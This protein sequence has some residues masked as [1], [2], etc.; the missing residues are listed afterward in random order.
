[1]S[2]A[3][4]KANPKVRSSGVRGLSVE[5]PDRARSG[6]E[7]L[8]GADV[9]PSAMKADYALPPEAGPNGRRLQD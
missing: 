9:R 7:S 3:T 5:M 2:E 4:R 6:N 8:A 1:M